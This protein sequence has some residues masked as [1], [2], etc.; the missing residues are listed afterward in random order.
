MPL[1]KRRDNLKGEEVKGI[2]W[3]YLSCG[4]LSGN[5]KGLQVYLLRDMYLDLHKYEVPHWR[6]NFL[7][8]RKKYFNFQSKLKIYE[9]NLCFLVL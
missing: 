2:V 5:F 7:R 3:L 6:E 4:L 9:R 1:L 8:V